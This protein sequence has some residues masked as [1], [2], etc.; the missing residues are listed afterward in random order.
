MALRKVMAQMRR[1]VS[2]VTST[3]ALVACI[4]FLWMFF[5]AATLERTA[6]VGGISASPGRDAR[7]VAYE[8]AAK[9]RHGM[10]GNSPVYM[11]GFFAV[12][13]AIW[14]W[15]A[16]KRLRRILAE[17]FPLLG[18]AAV[19]AALLAPYAAPRILSDFVAQESV[20]VSHASSSGT[21]IASA[22]GVYSLLTWSTVVIAS[23]WSIRLRS[24]KPL[25]IPLGLNL[26]LAFVR[27]WTVADFTSRWLRQAL[28][29]EPSAVISFL[30]VP[31]IPGFLAWVELRPTRQK[32]SVAQKRESYSK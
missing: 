19:F 32:T 7:A 24:L 25:L 15:C 13:I 30:L 22:Q 29:G 8:F 5:A 10:A 16:G 28:D 6:D 31:M 20:S 3:L 14:F 1:D 27:P 26:V 18:A 21:W 4:F 23:R 17:G 11:P 2:F 9:W 12:A